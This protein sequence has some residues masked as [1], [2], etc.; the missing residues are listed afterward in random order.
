MTWIRWLS[1][2][3]SRELNKV[4]WSSD[5]VKAYFAIDRPNTARPGGD[6]VDQEVEGAAEPGERSASP[7]IGAIVGGVLGGVALVAGAF[8][9]FCL[10][11]RRNRRRE[12]GEVPEQGQGDSKPPPVE[13]NSPEQQRMMEL[14]GNAVSEVGYVT[15][16]A[17]Q[18]AHAVEVY[19]DSVYYQ[20]AHQG[21]KE[22][23]AR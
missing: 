4:E 16:D 5:E 23:D 21:A 11:R 7:P 13:L 1:N 17:Y 20:G 2:L 9:A 12:V 19:G 15:E 18:K 8:V 6:G 3:F 14:D 10:V 22:L